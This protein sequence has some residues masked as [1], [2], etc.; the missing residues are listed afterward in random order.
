MKP[1]QRWEISLSTPRS[2]TRKGST[3]KYDG[4]GGGPFNF[5]KVNGKI[6]GFGVSSIRHDME[7]EKTTKKRGGAV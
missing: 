2:P 7:Y 3:Y 6:T 4:A 5:G 1:L